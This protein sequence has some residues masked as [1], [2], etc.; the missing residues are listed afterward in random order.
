MECFLRQNPPLDETL[1][2]TFADYA[3]ETA[4]AISRKYPPQM[5]DLVISVEAGGFID[6]MVALMVKDILHENGSFR[7]LTEEERITAD[8]LMFSDVLPAI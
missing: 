5:R 6:G 3:L 2:K 1:K 7:K 8:L 4:A